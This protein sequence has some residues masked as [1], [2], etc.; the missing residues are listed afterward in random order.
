MGCV[1]VGN[2]HARRVW[3][4]VRAVPVPWL[5]LTSSIGIN[6]P[7]A[8]WWLCDCRGD[9]RSPPGVSGRAPRRRGWGAA[10]K[11]WG[12]LRLWVMTRVWRRGHILEPM[13]A[14]SAEATRALVS[15]MTAQLAACSASPL[16]AAASTL[17]LVN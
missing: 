8:S 3:W 13:V 16:A 17:A 5:A 12:Q 1:G 11:W 10:A 6:G 9:V 7:R 4:I 14:P 15:P 2:A